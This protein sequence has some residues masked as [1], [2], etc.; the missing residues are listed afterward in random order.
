MPT[1]E[2]RSRRRRLVGVVLI[3]WVV[4]AIMGGAVSWYISERGS[5][6]LRHD[7]NALVCVLRSLVIPQ[8][9]RSQQAADDPTQSASARARA[10][11]AIVTYDAVLKGLLTVP[12][13]YD[14]S[15]FTIKA[16]SG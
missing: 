7:H 9:A 10:K 16:T 8:K 3:V 15:G 13:G 14:C 6:E 11:S 12:P 1:L 2:A 5:R 4:G